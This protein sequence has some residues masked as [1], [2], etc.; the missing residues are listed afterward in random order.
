ML[1][2]NDEP[3]EQETQQLVRIFTAQCPGYLS[4]LKD[5][6]EEDRKV[7][8]VPAD[9]GDFHAALS[10][11]HQFSQVF[12]SD[13]EIQLELAKVANNAVNYYGIAQEFAQLEDWGM[14]LVTLAETSRW[15]E[16]QEIQFALAAG[17]INAVLSTNGD[18]FTAWKSRLNR[19]ARRNNGNLEIQR[20]IFDNDIVL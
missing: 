9:A 10:R 15:L 11:L 20:L 16:D 1:C 4:D 8:S 2:S 3:Y 18:Q 5:R 13:R 6:F 17:A 19:C 7:A 14:R 12:H